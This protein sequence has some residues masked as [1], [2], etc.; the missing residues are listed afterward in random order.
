MFQQRVAAT[1][2][3]HASAP[4]AY[5]ARSLP[6]PYWWLA[7]VPLAPGAFCKLGMNHGL[8]EA[9]DAVVV[10]ALLTA[11]ALPF[12]ASLAVRPHQGTKT[13]RTMIQAPVPT[14]DT[15]AKSSFLAN[16]SHEIRTSMNGILGFAQLLLECDLTERQRQQV[17]HI[18][19][20]GQSL[21]TILNDILDYARI[22][23][24]RMT[25]LTEEFSPRL[26]LENTARL[27]R[28]AAAQK[29]LRLSLEYDRSLPATLLGDELRFSQIVPNLVGNAIKFTH[30]G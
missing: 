17:V 28:G 23:T 1:P 20:S 22:E 15:D 14:L 3:D 18:H 10:F 7:L 27:M 21:V 12:C 30:E 9:G 8:L 24:G 11:L 26:A 16:M 6:G 5:G 13:E 2:D 19:E 25:L 4:T 29:G